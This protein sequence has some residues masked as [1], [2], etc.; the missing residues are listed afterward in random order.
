MR[1]WEKR[2][3]YDEVVPLEIRVKLSRPAMLYIFQD[4][5]RPPPSWL[6]ENFTDTGT[7][8]LLEWPPRQNPPQARTTNLVH[9]LA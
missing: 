7:R 3:E 1:L 5:R 8:L 4:A 6:R 2:A 9:R